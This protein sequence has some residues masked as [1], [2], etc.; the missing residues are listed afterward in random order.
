MNRIPRVLQKPLFALLIL[1]LLFGSSLAQGRLNVKREELGLTRVTP[2]ENAP[3]MLA[4]TTVALGGFRGLLADALWSRLQDLQLEG[5]FFEMVQLSDWITKLYPTFS[6]VWVHLAWNMSYNISVKFEAMEEKWRWV[7]RGIEMLRDE[8]LKYNPNSVDIYRELAWHY[9][10]KL[11]M[12]MDDANRYYKTVLAREMNEVFP[13]G[14]AN[15]EPLVNPQTPE[16][17]ARRERIVEDFKLDPETLL[18][19]DTE[20]GPLDWRLPEAHAVY[21]GTA[22]LQKIEEGLLFDPVTYERI[23]REEFIKLRR[24]VYQSMQLAFR[25]GRIV[26][27]L[28]ELLENPNYFI[29]TGPNLD[30]AEA[31]NRAYESMMEEDDEY[32]EHI[33]TGHEN[34]LRDAVYY[35]FTHNR[36]PEATRWFK[37]LLEKYPDSIE[38]GQD[39]ESYAIS[40]VA[41]VVGGMSRDRIRLALEGFF[42]NAFYSW[43]IG[44]EDQAASYEVFARKVYENYQAKTT[45]TASSERRIAFRKTYAQLREEAL[46]RN[47][48]PQTSVLPPEMI[49]RLRTA[50]ELPADF[51]LEE[52]DPEDSQEALQPVGA[53]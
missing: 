37:Y 49:L 27:D 23:K 3:P 42:E 48:N 40:R 21:W 25:R 7:R 13:G 29:D 18:F 24:T 17:E 16:D 9:Q 28:G 6:D 46:I 33:S 34:M 14:D 31:T 43:A 53:L 30:I 5:K 20:Y 8:G 2:L 12:A 4:F 1:V 39:I 35:F 10:H 45:D 51:G 52:S 15:A 32:R 44:D 19:V 36:L 26:V 22:G 41:D 50:L 47:V 38:P 11:G